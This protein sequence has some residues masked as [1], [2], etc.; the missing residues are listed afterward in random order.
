M[1][2]LR[3][4]YYTLLIIAAFIG[5]FML[6]SLNTYFSLDGI[7][8]GKSVLGAIIG[9]IIAVELFKKVMKI[10]SSTGAYFGSRSGNY[11]ISCTT[12]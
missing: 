6:G 9:G 2:I 4:I 5:A 3:Y 10:D 1:K 7:I 12:F 8:I 11:R